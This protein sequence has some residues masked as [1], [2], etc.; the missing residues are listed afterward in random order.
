[1]KKTYW[2]IVSSRLGNGPLL[3]RKEDADAERDEMLRAEPMDTVMV[4]SVEMTQD[5]YE[6]LPEFQG[7]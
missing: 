5:Q 2:Q 3:E 4:Q 6:A 1:M 7:Y